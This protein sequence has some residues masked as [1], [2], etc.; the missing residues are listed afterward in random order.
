VI[1]DAPRTGAGFVAVPLLV[2]D[3]AVG[4]LAFGYD[5]ALDEDDLVFLEAAAGHLGQTLQRVRLSESLE[6]RADEIEFIADVMRS[7][8]AATDHR[9]LLRV[10]AAA[11]VPRLG[12]L[13]SVHFVP[14]PGAETEVAVANADPSHASL[15]EG[16]G[17]RFPY[18]PD[19]KAGVG[20][21]LRTGQEEVIP[22]ITPTMLGAAAARFD[23]PDVGR[24]L[25]ALGFLSSVTVPITTDGRVIGAMQALA[26]ADSPGRQEDRLRLARAVAGGIGEALHNRWLTDQQAHIATTLQRAFLPP[27]LPSIPGLEVAVAYWPAGLAN[28]VGGD[29]YDVFRLDERRWAV[30]IG[31]ACGTGPDAAATAAI[32]RHTARAAARHGYGHQEVLSWVNQAVKHS[33][34]DLF[35]TACFATIDLTS[36]GVATVTV[37]MAGHPLP[38]H[39][40]ND[41][42][43]LIG[44]PGTLL[45]V[46]DDAAWH[47]D[48][49]TL[50]PGD[51]LVL[52]TDG[53]TDLPPPHLRDEAELL[54]LLDA[55]PKPS[56]AGDVVEYL[57]EDLDRRVSPYRRADDV[58]L[59]VFHNLDAASA[60]SATSDAPPTIAA[61]P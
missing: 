32:A 23:D 26:T 37:A 5:G 2:Q 13:C 55:L 19:A 51:S 15:A 43:R 56:R 60:T 34:R 52:Y 36:E 4:V 39:I 29:F 40:A 38:V 7:V 27:A 35:C 1:D 9:T 20:A 42:S 46:F 49:A 47:V 44:Q 30:L 48:E 45:G 24:R 57:R 28:Y 31:D 53:I 54:A 22:E 8:V 16:L 59:L 50:A 21:V 6:R 25:E 3:D 12:S 17:R 41:A 14:E 33:D 10:V 11:A 58:A 61:A 18:D